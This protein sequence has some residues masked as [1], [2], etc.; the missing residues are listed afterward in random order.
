MF[1][2]ISP[3]RELLLSIVL[4][5]SQPSLT[6]LLLSSL[7]LS[8]FFRVTMVVGC[9]RAVTPQ[10]IVESALERVSDGD[11]PKLVTR[12]FLF[13]VVEWSEQLRPVT[14]VWLGAVRRRVQVR[15]CTSG[16]KSEKMFWYYYYYYYKTRFTITSQSCF[17]LATFRP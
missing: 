16:C 1:G 6:V 14:S 4:I 13:E 11:S 5:K 8:Y 7:R 3:P 2:V 9:S 12:P 17:S 10:C 15:L